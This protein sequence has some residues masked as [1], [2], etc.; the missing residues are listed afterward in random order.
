MLF[1]SAAALQRAAGTALPVEHAPE[2]PGEQRRSFIR[3]AKAKAALGWTPETTL[4]AGLRATY[5]WFR[6]RTAS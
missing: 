1:R 4:D 2:R 3:N 6:A 5:D